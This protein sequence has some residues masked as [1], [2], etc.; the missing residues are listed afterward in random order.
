MPKFR[1]QA[2]VVPVDIKVTLVPI[3]ESVEARGAA[4]GV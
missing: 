4:H 3:L 1:T 2:L